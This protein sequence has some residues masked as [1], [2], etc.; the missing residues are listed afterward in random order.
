MARSHQELGN[1]EKAKQLFQRILSDYP[2]SFEARPAE[3]RLKDL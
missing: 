1:L 2:E 3:E